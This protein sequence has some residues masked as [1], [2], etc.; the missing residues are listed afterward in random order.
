MC[1]SALALAS[2]FLDSQDYTR[3]KAPNS[4]FYSDNTNKF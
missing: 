1:D 4:M 2:D 3:L